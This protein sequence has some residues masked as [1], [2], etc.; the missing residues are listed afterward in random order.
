MP[1]K[2]ILISANGMM[3]FYF[4]L[5]NMYIF[6][7]SGPKAWN[8]FEMFWGEGKERRLCYSEKN[9]SGSRDP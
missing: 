9:H 6:L 4:I 1:I 5:K 2:S 7:N 8:V 3:R